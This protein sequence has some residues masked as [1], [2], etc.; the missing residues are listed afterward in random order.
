MSNPLRVVV[1][2]NVV[3][4]AG[5]TDGICRAVIRD[6]VARH[7]MLLSEAILQEY[8]EVIARPK[9]ASKYVAFQRLLDVLT[10]TATFV[11]PAQSPYVLPDPDDE[12]YLAAALAGEAEAQSSAVPQHRAT[13]RRLRNKT[14]RMY[15]SCGE[16]C[17]LLR[18]SLQEY[19]KKRV[20]ACLL[21]KPLNACNT[22]SG[23]KESRLA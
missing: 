18:M 19:V 14:L 7:Q 16:R 21:R 5:L 15:W 17:S 12:I 10:V 11:A 4:A 3:V 2:C 9:F 20:S 1:D 8:L 22:L 13:K 6:V 23:S